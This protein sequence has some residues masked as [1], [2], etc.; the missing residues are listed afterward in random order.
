MTGAKTYEQVLSECGAAFPRDQVEV[1]QGPGGMSLSYASQYYVLK[2]LSEV[3]GLDWSHAIT[4]LDV[5]HAEA[6]DKG[7]VVSYRCVSQL[8]VRVGDVRSYHEDVG[9]G[10]G[11]DKSAGKAHESA[12]K[13]A[14]TDSLKRCARRLGDSFGLAL[15]D[16]TQANIVDTAALAGILRSL[17]AAATPV[18]ITALR[19]EA[20]VLA[21]SLDP[22]SIEVLRVA[23]EAAK[24][25]VGAG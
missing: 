4:H 7:H 21:S 23:V 24:A 9:F 10:D 1:R 17:E 16:K 19:K 5:V 13:E 12:A 22:A 8:E 11:R 15:Y 6:T 14:V 20:R 18:D 2:R 25:R 3:F